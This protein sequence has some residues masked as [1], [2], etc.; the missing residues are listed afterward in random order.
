MVGRNVGIC[1]FPARLPQCEASMVWASWALRFRERTRDAARA[2]WGLNPDSATVAFPGLL[3]RKAGR[4]QDGESRQIHLWAGLDAPVL[5]QIVL[6]VVLTA[7]HGRYGRIFSTP[8]GWRRIVAGQSG[9]RNALAQFSAKKISGDQNAGIRVVVKQ[10]GLGPF[11]RKQALCGIPGRIACAR[12]VGA[13]LSKLLLRR[14][15]AARRE[16]RPFPWLAEQLP[17]DSAWLSA[18]AIAQSIALRRRISFSFG[19]S[20]PSAALRRSSSSSA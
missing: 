5:I 6:G 17:D 2:P 4:S 11:L 14:K 9:G 19:F 3:F 13:N 12:C 18:W 10:T 1:S 16:G 8:A 15:F 20:L 7:A